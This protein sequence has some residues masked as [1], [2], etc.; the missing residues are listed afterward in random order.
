MIQPS[1]FLT[2]AQTLSNASTSQ[3]AEQKFKQYAQRHNL[4][5]SESTFENHQGL[6]AA[7]QSQKN[8][9]AARRVGNQLQ[10]LKKDRTVA[11]YKLSV[12]VNSNLAKKSCTASQTIITGSQQI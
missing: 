3:E 5:I 7:L 11:D 6:I 1:D 12:A 9:D 4:P 8:S 2:V 10:Q